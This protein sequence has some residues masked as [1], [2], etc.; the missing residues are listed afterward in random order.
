MSN[1][2][3][4]YFKLSVIVIMLS[5]FFLISCEKKEDKVSEQTISTS[6]QQKTSDTLI[7]KPDTISVDYGEIMNKLFT[8]VEKVR[9]N[10]DSKHPR[11]ELLKV[12]LD[13]SR[14]KIYAL[15]EGLP[16]TTAIS[17][18]MAIQTAE[19]AALADAARWALLTIS[20]REN[21]ANL[22]FTD[23]LSGKVPPHHIVFKSQLPGNKVYRLIELDM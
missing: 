23:K 21:P 9:T 5:V 11:L 6:E 13:S 16:D 19:R 17:D 2:T 14:Q 10:P 3:N 8:L 22:S 1:Y 18:A 12:A 15:G 7:L 4:F 20:W